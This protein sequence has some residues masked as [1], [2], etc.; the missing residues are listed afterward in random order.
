MGLTII[1]SLSDSFNIT[2]IPGVGV[3]LVIKKKFH[4]V[5]VNG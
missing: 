5:I 2:S 4:P 3:K 1:D